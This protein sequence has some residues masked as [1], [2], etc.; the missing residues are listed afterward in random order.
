MKGY[1]DCTGTL[2]LLEGQKR[3]PQ[4]SRINW[5]KEEWPMYKSSMRDT[6]R[7]SMRD[8]GRSST[9]ASVDGVQ[10]W[11]LGQQSGVGVRPLA[12]ESQRPGPTK[13]CD[14]GDKFQLFWAS[15]TSF[16]GTW[17]RWKR[18]TYENSCISRCPDSLL[19]YWF[20]LLFIESSSVP[21]YEGGLDSPSMCK[22]L[23]K[24]FF[25]WTLSI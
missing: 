4:G 2:D 25:P 13:P 15:V 11:G 17:W 20:L 3:S 6:G 23:G 21:S 12:S 19:I 5:A 22:A 14:L 7:S 10:H 16:R 18:V 1:R 24:C 9:R 8:T